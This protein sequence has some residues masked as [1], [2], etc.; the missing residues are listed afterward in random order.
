[1][2]EFYGRKIE[3]ICNGITLT[4]EL[5]IT[6]EI[7]FD[8]TP[9]VNTARIKIYNLLDQTIIKF[10]HNKELIINAGYQGNFGAV[11]KGLVKKVETEWEGPDKLTTITVADLTDNWVG[12]TFEKTYAEDVYASTILRDAANAVGIAIGQILLPE[13]KIYK[14]GKTI[15]GEASKTIAEIVPDCNAY[16]N[17]AYGR[18]WIQG[19]DQGTQSGVLLNKDSGLIGTPIPISKQEDYKVNKIVHEEVTKDGKTWTEP[20]NV[21]ETNRRMFYGYKIRMMLNYRIGADSIFKIESSTANAIL[22]VENG[23]HDGSEF[24]T[25]VEAYAQVDMDDGSFYGNDVNDPNRGKPGYYQVED[26][27]WVNW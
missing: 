6:F 13:D 26:G 12:K 17:V 22:R 2:A 1:M 18:L 10:E 4:N 3:I 21:E 7:P 5:D 16:M 9:S 23:K 14:G 8:N 19:R 27:S 24:I 25:E 20:K 15:K 11:L